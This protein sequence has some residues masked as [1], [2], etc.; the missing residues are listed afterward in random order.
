MSFT[1]MGID[2]MGDFGNSRLQAGYISG[3]DDQVAFDTNTQT[4]VDNGSAT[5]N[6]LSIQGLHTFKTE[7]GKPTWVPV[8]RYENYTKNDGDDKYADLVLGVSYF[9]KENVKGM[10]EY[11]TD[12][13][14]PD[15]VDKENRATF[16][17]NVGL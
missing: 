6:V 4:F 16:Q 15:G 2:F 14:T 17:V 8:A 3:K 13:T 12:M 9:L 7:K 5:D 10:L 11:K 1:R